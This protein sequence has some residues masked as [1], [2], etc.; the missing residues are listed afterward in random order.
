MGEVRNLYKIWSENLTEK[1]YA[2]YLDVDARILLKWIL[3]KRSG[4]V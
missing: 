1:D 2:E 4:R 3:G